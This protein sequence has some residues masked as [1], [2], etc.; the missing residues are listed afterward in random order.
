MV[1]NRACAGCRG[2]VLLEPERSAK[3]QASDTI[4][5]R[6]DLLLLFAV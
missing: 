3:E 1:D 2:V 6:E 4:G 5:T